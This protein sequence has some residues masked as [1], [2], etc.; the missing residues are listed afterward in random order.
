MQEAQYEQQ[1]EYSTKLQKYQAEIQEYSAEINEITTIVSNYIA[2]SQGYQQNAEKYYTWAQ[3]E[4]Q[5]Y[6]QNN[7]KTMALQQSQ[8]R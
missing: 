5:S 2:V 1:A 7:T 8:Q 3:Q 6:I 4:I